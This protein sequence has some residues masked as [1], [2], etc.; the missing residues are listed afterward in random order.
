M[1]TSRN[2]IGAIPK[3]RADT[4]DAA[5]LFNNSGSDVTV[6]TAAVRRL[7][8]FVFYNSIT[9]SVRNSISTEDKR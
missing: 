4:P 6:G 8:Q 2:I 1:P 5:M 7:R 3:K 9:V